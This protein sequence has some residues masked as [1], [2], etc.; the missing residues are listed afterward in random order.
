MPETAA[1]GRAVI[2]IPG[3]E[4]V[5]RFARRDLLVANLQ[6]LETRPLEPGPGVLIDGEAG[7]RLTPSPLRGGEATGPAIDVF[8]AYW[9][10][11]AAG[12]GELTPWARLWSGFDL[13]LYWV[14]SP[15]TWRAFGRSSTIALGL[16]AG[17]ALLVLWYLSLAIL[18]AAALRADPTQTQAIAGIPLL[19]ALLDGFFAATGWIEAT[20]PWAIIT[21]ALAA[22]KADE[23]AAMAQFSKDY[24]ENRRHDAVMGLRDRVRHRVAATVERV[25]AEPYG[26]IVLVGHSFGS[27]IAIDLLAGWPHPG[28]WPRLR[29]VTLGSPEA[30]LEC[31][32]HWLAAECR[33]L[34]ERQPAA[35][36]DCFSPSDWLCA[37]V[38]G[39]RQVYPESSRQLVFEGPRLDRLTGRTHMYYY[40]DAR[41]LE[42]LADARSLAP[43]SAD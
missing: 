39:H 5:E 15:R 12:P 16:M 23:L 28:D 14:F 7:K 24:L 21:L 37:A 22:F 20:A 25:L 30:V 32:S 9:A 42:I 19:K 35:W 36:V 38:T 40:Y 31:R 27:V 6:L 34:L 8:E 41:V 43:R 18:V 13:L 26:E 10:D 17:G 11:M 3:L 4:K 1:A 33:R 2:L 29:L